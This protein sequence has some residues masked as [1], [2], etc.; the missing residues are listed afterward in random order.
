MLKMVDCAI[1]VC[2]LKTNETATN[3]PEKN[4]VLFTVSTRLSLECKKKRPVAP[5]A[6]PNWT[7]SSSEFLPHSFVRR[8]SFVTQSMD[9]VKIYFKA[10]KKRRA[11]PQVIKVA[12]RALRRANINGLI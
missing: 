4:L 12:N 2:A 6:V 3:S 11:R 10:G 5:T 7:S 8:E 1:A 9:E